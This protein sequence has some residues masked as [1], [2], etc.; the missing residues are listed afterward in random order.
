MQ[1]SLAK[2]GEL[3]EVYHFMMP[4][5]TTGERNDGTELKRKKRSFPEIGYISQQLEAEHNASRC[6]LALLAWRM[7]IVDIAC[8]V[9]VGFALQQQRRRMYKKDGYNVPNDPFWEDQWSLVRF[10]PMK[11][12]LRTPL[13]DNV[14]VLLCSNCSF[15]EYPPL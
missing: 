3:E 15:G 7:H 1:L 14:L 5:A 4:W 8:V 10:S 11:F 2:V 12:G 6:R 9:Q 13:Q